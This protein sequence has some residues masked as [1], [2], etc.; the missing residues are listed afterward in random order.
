MNAE[1]RERWLRFRVGVFVLV[2]LAAF[3]G[4]IY[5]LGARARLFEARYTIH[6]D[7]VEVGGLAEGAT[8]R[9][10]GVQ[11]GRVSGVHLPGQPG[12]RVRVD[13]TIARRYAD[14]IRQDSVARIETQG[15]LGDRIVEITV[16]SASAPPVPAGATL[17][18]RDPFEMSRVLDEGAQTV[19]HVAALAQSLQRATEAFGH[20]RVLEDIAAAAAAARRAADGFAGVMG[21]IERGE[22]W[23]RVLLQ[24][25][26]VALRR[27]DALI[28]S[29]RAVVDRVERGEGAA[30]V[31]TSAESGAAARRFL[32]AL[33]RL[34]GLAERAAAGEGLLPALLLDPRYRET[35]DH[36][37]DTV[38]NLKTLSDRLAAGQGALGTLLQDES[39][40]DALRDTLA[41]LR[42]AVA[43]LRIVGERLEAGEGS[44]GALLAD[45]TLYD[46][47]VAVL[48]GTERSRL[49]RWMLRR[50][51]E[52]ERTPGAPR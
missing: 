8:V 22:G 4:S 19:R 38:A 3:L 23:A 50:L 10:A 30:G 14:R 9:L 26:P 21:R 46:R 39:G 2:G 27:L 7:F 5:A 6:A 18:S 34:T 35:A 11:I 36:L 40:G 41:D 42:S 32:A 52:P 43:H 28:A 24:E 13:L 37:R 33:D 51:S 16:G 49:L 45:P 47:L 17:A 25:E 15:L 20:S 31:L 48:E 29:A 1:P 12:G 44:L